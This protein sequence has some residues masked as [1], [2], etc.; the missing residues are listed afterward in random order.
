MSD[1][2]VV[3]IVQIVISQGCG[4]LQ[5]G[6]LVFA[7]SQAHLH[8]A[9]QLRPTFDRHMYRSR[10][11]VAWVGL[12][13]Y[14]FGS[15]LVQLSGTH[16][17]IIGTAVGHEHSHVYLGYRYKQ[18]GDRCRCFVSLPPAPFSR[19]FEPLQSPCV[20]A[21]AS[22]IIPVYKALYSLASWYKS[23]RQLA[24]QA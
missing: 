3:V 1:C 7:H 21:P 16:A 24:D 9:Y 15:S 6:S 22:A 11:P 10:I 20:N 23:I 12:P 8:H 17:T 5:A 2:P 18:L 19:L 4:I 13:C 14:G